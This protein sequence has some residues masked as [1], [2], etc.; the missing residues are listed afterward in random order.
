MLCATA[1]RARGSLARPVLARL[2]LSGAAAWECDEGGPPSGGVALREE[3]GPPNRTAGLGARGAI[4][5]AG[6]SKQRTDRRH[7]TRWAGR[8]LPVLVPGETTCESWLG[9]PSGFRNRIGNRK[10]H[11][12]GAAFGVGLRREASDGRSAV[13]G[14]LD[15]PRRGGG[16]PFRIRASVCEIAVGQPQMRSRRESCWLTRRVPANASGV[17]SGDPG[18]LA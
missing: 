15:C 5:A 11:R 4:R 1:S 16:V 10:A 3:V 7:G 14:L 9:E 6:H 8:I 18:P 12:I 17:R 13:A 2:Q